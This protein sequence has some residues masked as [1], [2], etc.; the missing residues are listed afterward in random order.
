MLV[1]LLREEKIESGKEG[2]GVLVP[3]KQGEK[4]PQPALLHSHLTSV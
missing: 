4:P 3:D 2:Q 1:M